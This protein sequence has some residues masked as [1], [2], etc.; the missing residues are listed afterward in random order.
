MTTSEPP[1]SHRKSADYKKWTHYS[2]LSLMTGPDSTLLRC[3][4]S[5]DLSLMSGTLFSFLPIRTLKVFNCNTIPVKFHFISILEGGFIGAVRHL[6]QEDPSLSLVNALSDT[7]VP[8]LEAV[9]S[10]SGTGVVQV[11]VPG[12]SVLSLAARIRQSVTEVNANL[13]STVPAT[14]AAASS[15]A[16]S[17]GSMMS[18]ASSM[19]KA[20][21]RV[22]DTSHDEEGLKAKAATSPLP[23]PVSVSVPTSPQRPVTGNTATDPDSILPD[24]SASSAGVSAPAPTPPVATPSSYFGGFGKKISAFGASSLDSVRNNIAAAQ[25]AHQQQQEQAKLQQQQQQQNPGSEKGAVMWSSDISVPS[26]SSARPAIEGGLGFM[27][28]LRSAIVSKINTA[29]GTGVGVG[30]ED[31]VVVPL[32]H[33]GTGST[34]VIDGDDEDEGEGDR[35]DGMGPKEEVDPHKICVSKTD[36][37][38]TQVIRSKKN[39]FSDFKGA[40]DVLHRKVI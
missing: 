32:G 40:T 35:D 34:F 13:R 6:R 17:M 12:A 20:P 28:G 33:S 10:Y 30:A 21:T 5:K 38:R 36:L 3:S 2:P 26:S 23:A 18:M 14:P 4:F 19:I 8:V 31:R 39:E 11:P 7:S 1:T 25:L 37:E 29:R 24:A 27:S 9:L 15:V 22:V 16:P